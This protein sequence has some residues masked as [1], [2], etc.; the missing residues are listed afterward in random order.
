MNLFLELKLQIN[1]LYV[2]ALLLLFF[3]SVS[4]EANKYIAWKS[5]KM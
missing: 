1:D 2:I 4:Y 3:V 5:W